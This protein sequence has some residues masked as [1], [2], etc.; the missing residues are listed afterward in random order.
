MIFRAVTPGVLMPKKYYGG[1]SPPD[2][3]FFG[4]FSRVTFADPC[5]ESAFLW[6]LSAFWPLQ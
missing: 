4:A 6:V 2:L 5:Q 1:L 3:W